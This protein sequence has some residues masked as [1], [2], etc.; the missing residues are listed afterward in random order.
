MAETV[1]VHS[2]EI[3]PAGAGAGGVVGTTGA[4]VAGIDGGI[5]D[6]A[7]V[8]WAADE[9]DRAAV[10]LRLVSV[11]DS[12]VQ[13]TPYEVLASGSPSLEDRLRAQLRPVLDDAAARA[14]AR[15]AVLDVAVCAPLDNVAAALV[16]FSKT[17]ELLVVGGPEQGRLH[18]ALLG[19]VAMT[20][21]AHA[22]CPV[23][24][25]PAGTIVTAPQ[26]IVVGVDGSD[27]G[28]RAVEFALRTAQT[29]GATVTCVLAWNVEVDNGV[30]VTEPSSEH[31]SA[32]QDRYQELGHRVVGPLARGHP[33]VEVHVLVRHGP[34]A[35]ALLQAASEVKADQLVVGSR[36]RGGFKGLLLGSVSRSVVEHA[37]RP[38]AVVH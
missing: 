18:R 10:P 38:V 16:R 24:V 15:H 5:A 20:V 9:A 36:G 13:M 19:S 4:V 14:R 25:V 21:V 2:S 1:P 28:G 29:C 35:K 12:G 22:R 8:D 32:V 26:R 33:L 34:P 17:A 11:I 6:G 7:V 23:V 30:V 27:T 3:G 37:D 31:W